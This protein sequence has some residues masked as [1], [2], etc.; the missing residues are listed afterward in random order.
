MPRWPIET[1][2]KQCEN[3]LGEVVVEVGILGAAH[4]VDK[5]EPGTLRLRIL[6]RTVQ[7]IDD[8]LQRGCVRNAQRTVSIGG[9]KGDGS[10]TGSACGL[11][12]ETEMIINA[13]LE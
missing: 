1:H 13:F 12:S 10:A 6:E 5:N 8:A 11:K 9:E 7:L 4:V 2:L 3:L